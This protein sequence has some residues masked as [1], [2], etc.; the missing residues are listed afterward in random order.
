MSEPN[1]LDQ[2]PMTASQEPAAYTPAASGHGGFVS[3]PARDANKRTDAKA[4]G[5]VWDLRKR[6]RLHRKSYRQPGNRRFQRRD[7]SATTQLDVRALAMPE[8]HRTSMQPN[9]IER[10][11]LR[12][13][14]RALRRKLHGHSLA[15]ATPEHTPSG[16]SW[17]GTARLRRV[18]L[19][20]LVALQTLLATWS[21]SHTF[22]YPTLRASEIA[23]LTLFAIL[24]SWISLGFWSAV[25]GFW[26]LL[27]GSKEF[28]AADVPV[29]ESRPLDA[30][31]AVLMPIC[32]EDV[33]R[34]FAGL[35]ATYRSL[36][37][38]PQFSSFDFLC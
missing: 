8:I 18:T 23:I 3:T 7:V 16:A 11:P 15:V 21:L 10:N 33:D 27:R 36:A 19:F 12:R 20:I 32:N 37:R 29:E 30:R 6:E 34:V 38:L 17:H 5:H 35:E 14:L 9:V 28:V 31:I 22:P 25:A 2:S 26:T 4:P 1:S 24:F 13:L